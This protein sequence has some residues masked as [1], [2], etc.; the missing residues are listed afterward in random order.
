MPGFLHD[1]EL[2]VLPEM[3]AKLASD[4]NVASTSS[5]SCKIRSSPFESG[6]IGCGWGLIKVGG[7]E[8]GNP[9]RSM[10][11]LE[12]RRTLERGAANLRSVA[13][14]TASLDANK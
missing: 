1:A 14:P 8:T 6:T 5:R 7:V 4:T 12:A 13:L 11:V 2:T 9:K 3:T 10:S